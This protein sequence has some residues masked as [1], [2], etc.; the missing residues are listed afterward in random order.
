M[1]LT[2]REQIA[3]VAQRAPGADHSPSIVGNCTEIV[4]QRLALAFAA[5]I[6]QRFLGLVRIDARAGQVGG[7][8]ICD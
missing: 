1:A 2:D 5:Q 8:K 6:G 7:E 4:E 3:V